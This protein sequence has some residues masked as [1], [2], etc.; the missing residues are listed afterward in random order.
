MLEAVVVTF[1]IL[2]ATGPIFA[3]A[4]CKAA[5]REVTL[6][7]QPEASESDSDLRRAA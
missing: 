6:Q 5:A 1:I 4:L 2:S 7:H 3:L